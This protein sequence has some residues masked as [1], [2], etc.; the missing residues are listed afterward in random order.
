MLNRLKY[1]WYLLKDCYYITVDYVEPS[2]VPGGIGTSIEKQYIIYNKD[3]SID[4]T[5]D[6]QKATA[7]G[8]ILGGIIIKK[9]RDECKDLP[10]LQFS[11]ISVGSANFVDS[12]AN[13]AAYAFKSDLKK[14]PI[15]LAAQELD[16]V[17]IKN[18]NVW[19]VVSA[20][21]IDTEKKTHQK[22]IKIIVKSADQIP[23]FQKQF[24]DKYKDFPL[25]ITSK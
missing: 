20:G 9:L 18:P 25:E 2:K 17:L 24:G 4:Y 16:Q 15:D 23:L 21:R 22:W 10:N 12:V 13:G 1:Y 6:L 5:K 11:L 14:E 7:F 3:E 8:L 19:G